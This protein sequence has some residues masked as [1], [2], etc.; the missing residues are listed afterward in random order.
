M[1]MISCICEVILSG[2][3]DPDFSET[4][5]NANKSNMPRSRS[6]VEGELGAMALDL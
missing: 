3:H 4:L 2:V 1:Y 5:H 6:D